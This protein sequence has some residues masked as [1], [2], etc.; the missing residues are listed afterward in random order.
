MKV[1]KRFGNLL[2]SIVKLRNKGTWN[3]EVDKYMSEYDSISSRFTYLYLIYSIYDT[4]NSTVNQTA[5][6]FLFLIIASLGSSFI[7]F[8]F[9]A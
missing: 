8:G 5:S 3:G 1:E 6:D 9:F 7:Y 4:L 2:R